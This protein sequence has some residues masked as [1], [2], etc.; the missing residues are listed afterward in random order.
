MSG[1]ILRVTQR[2]V[3]CWV[4]DL[5]ALTIVVEEVMVVATRCDNIAGLGVYEEALS[6]VAW[7]DRIQRGRKGAMGAKDDGSRAVRH[8]SSYA[9]LCDKS[10]S[11]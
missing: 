2:V 10:L 7:Y 11:K 4:R 8:L 9:V 5:D 3:V 6:G 1:C